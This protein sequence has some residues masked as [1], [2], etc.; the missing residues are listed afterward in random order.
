MLLLVCQL[1]SDVIGYMRTFTRHWCVSIRL[2]LLSK[3]QSLSTTVLFRTTITR[4]IMLH[5]LMKHFLCRS[6]I[7]K[8]NPPSCRQRGDRLNGKRKRRKKTNEI[9]ITDRR[10]RKEGRKHLPRESIAFLGTFL[11]TLISPA[12]FC[13]A[14]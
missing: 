14:G 8:V 9:G 11:L 1:S 13:H 6:I 3:R 5:P 12:D 2:D 7:T 10:A 4:T